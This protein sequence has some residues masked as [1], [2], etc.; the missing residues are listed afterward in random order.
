MH[1]SR[2]HHT[3]K[4]E[5][6]CL[7]KPWTKTLHVYEPTDLKYVLLRDKV[8]SIVTAT[9]SPV[10]TATQTQSHTH[11]ASKEAQNFPT[12]PPGRQQFGQS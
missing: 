11:S 3:D 2:T 5:N 6:E 4:E 9:Y 7:N 12:N 1:L 8:L 10:D